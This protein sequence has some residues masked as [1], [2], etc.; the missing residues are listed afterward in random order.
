[1][2]ICLTALELTFLKDCKDENEQRMSLDFLVLLRNYH[3]KKGQMIYQPSWTLLWT[4]LCI[5]ETFQQSWC[6]LL[7]MCMLAIAIAAYKFFQNMHS[8]LKNKCIMAHVVSEVRNLG[9]ASP[10]VSSSGCLMRLQL[11]C[12]KGLQ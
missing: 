8:S 10:G 4:L 6:L 11:R 12:L 5:T 3:I 9:M 2:I 7:P 1:M